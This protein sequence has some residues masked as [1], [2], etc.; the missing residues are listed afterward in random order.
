MFWVMIPGSNVPCMSLFL[1]ITRMEHPKILFCEPVICI[2]LHKTTVGQKKVIKNLMQ[3]IHYLVWIFKDFNFYVVCMSRDVKTLIVEMLQSAK[4]SSSSWQLMSIKMMM[5][6]HFPLVYMQVTF[7]FLMLLLLSWFY[8]GGIF[9]FFN[10][11]PSL[12][13]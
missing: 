8:F 11:F 3:H 1:W 2:K 4:A 10:C 7:Y 9:M 12:Q 5:I 13:N 6:V